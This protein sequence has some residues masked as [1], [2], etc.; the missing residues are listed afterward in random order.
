M[1]RANKTADIKKILTAFENCDETTK[2]VV[3]GLVE[4]VVFL[5]RKIAELEK[6]I[7]KN[8]MFE[9]VYKANMAE[10]TEQR[11]AAVDTYNQFMKN[12]TPAVTKLQAIVENNT[13]KNPQEDEFMKFI[14]SRGGGGKA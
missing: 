13:A 1:A 9:T 5:N 2:A 14:N 6:D 4:R 3:S 10:P 8:G 12:Y 11:R 7:E